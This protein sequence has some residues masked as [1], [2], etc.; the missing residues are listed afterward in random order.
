MTSAPDRQPPGKQFQLRVTA[1]GPELDERLANYTNPTMRSRL[2]GFLHLF[3]QRSYVLDTS[4]RDVDGV[5]RTEQEFRA[6]KMQ[7]TNRTREPFSLAPDLHVDV[8]EQDDMLRTR[9]RLYLRVGLEAS[10]WLVVPPFFEPAEEVRHKLNSAKNELARLQYEAQLQGLIPLY[11]NVP[12]PIS[13]FEQ[14]AAEASL[15]AY[16]ETE[17]R[18]T[19]DELVLVE[20]IPSLRHRSHRQRQRATQEPLDATA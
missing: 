2:P 11:Y 8:I 14:I 15:R 9:L 5:S 10:K 18:A 4:D 13:R 7:V 3:S 12:Q 6:Y 20:N 16:L 17:P 1:I 19:V